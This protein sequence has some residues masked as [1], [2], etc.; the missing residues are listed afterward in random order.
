MATVYE[1]VP[2]SMHKYFH[3]VNLIAGAFVIYR[4]MAGDS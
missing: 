2:K 3:I 1:P 4:S